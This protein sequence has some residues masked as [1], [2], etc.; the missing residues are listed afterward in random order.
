[1]GQNSYGD[2][3]WADK[4][5]Y[6]GSG[7]FLTDVIYYFST[8]G[9]GNVNLKVWGLNAGAPGNVLAQQTVQISQLGT[10]GTPTVWS[11]PTPPSL[12]GNF[13]VG[14][15][16]NTLTNGDT[17][18]LMAAPTGTNTVWAKET[19]GWVDLATYSLDHS[20]AVIPVICNSSTT[21][22]KEILGTINEIL[23]FPNPSNGT[24]NVA[25]TEKKETTIEIYNLVGELIYT[26]GNPLNTQLFTI[27]IDNQPNGIYFVNIKSDNIITTKK[28]LIAK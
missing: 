8:S 27:N 17:V 20:A 22:E 21:G 2:N 9:T 7:T 13:F 19:T 28:V 6:T 14:H 3:G 23:V 12:N 16:H 1:M 10:G 4:I 25:L 18:A 26:S 24:L 11:I 15:D 5:P